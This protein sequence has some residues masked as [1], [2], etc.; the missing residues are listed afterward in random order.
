M[1]FARLR[2]GQ[3]AAAAP[4]QPALRPGLRIYAIGDI[5]GRLDLL[6]SLSV[7]ILQDLMGAPC[8]AATIVLLGDYIDR[9]PDSAGVVEFLSA[10]SFPGQTVALRGNHEAIFLKF[11][12]DPGVLDSWRQYGGLET[13]ASYGVDVKEA[14]RGRNF[15]K[16]RDELLRLLPE[17]HLE[18]LANTRLSFEA[19]DYFFCHAGVRPDVPLAQQRE[20]DLLWTRG[21]FNAHKGAFEKVIVHGH[22]PV[23]APQSMLYRI[24]VD[25]GA[26]ATGSLS[27]VVLEGAARRFLAT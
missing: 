16:A 10:E 23:D 20:E 27:C 2:P 1:F 3:V 17:R 4:F 18:F 21:R 7:K 26:Y 12:E 15:D 8:D 19:D 5:H 22:T 9:G 11:L 6:Q 14:M 13:L 25:T 24:N